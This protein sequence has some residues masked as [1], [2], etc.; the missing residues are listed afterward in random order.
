MA[1]LGRTKRIPN[2]DVTNILQLIK[3]RDGALTANTPIPNQAF[4]I[5]TS[6]DGKPA[7]IYFNGFASEMLNFLTQVHH[8]AT[9]YRE[10]HGKRATGLEFC[11]YGY[12][13][14]NGDIVIC[15][16]DST[17]IDEIANHDGSVNISKLASHNPTKDTRIDSTARMFE[18]IRHSGVVPNGFGKEPVALLGLIRPEDTIT[19][20]KYTPLLKEM[21]DVVLP[22]NAKVPTEFSTGVLIVPPAEMVKTKEGYKQITPSLECAL[23]RHELTNK[24]YANPVEI[25]N[26]TK[27]FGKTK[28]GDVVV[29]MSQNRQNLNG[30]PLP[31]LNIRTPK[32]A[33]TQEESSAN[34]FERDYEHTI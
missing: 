27:A 20:Q 22:G 16:V 32:E 3:D 6:N 31:K 18:Y 8:R 14:H 9:V 11:C 4:P 10:R 2:K 23:I 19:V 1:D 13:D 33:V 12:R 30:L 7:C 17:S 25:T 21:A 34:E 29:P 24:N 5:E 28:N 15:D 26:I